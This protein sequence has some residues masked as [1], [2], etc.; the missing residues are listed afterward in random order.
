MN[1][2]QYA[3]IEE[4]INGLMEPQRRQAFEAA[5]AADRQ[6]AETFHLYSVIEKE[7]TNREK[8]DEEIAALKRTLQSLDEGYRR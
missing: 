3:Q 7:M 4:Y 1:E 8:Y 6:L 2:E 5:L